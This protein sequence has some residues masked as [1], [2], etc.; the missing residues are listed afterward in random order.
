MV[1]STFLHVVTLIPQ[2]EGGKDILEGEKGCPKKI[3]FIS[4]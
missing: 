1:Y 2:A 4:L 3:I